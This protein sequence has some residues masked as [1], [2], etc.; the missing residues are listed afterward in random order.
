MIFR[1]G[2]NGL[3]SIK[4]SKVPGPIQKRE[5]DSVYHSYVLIGPICVV[6][7]GDTKK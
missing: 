2:N 7:D 5:H 3:F 1:D 4:R 6:A